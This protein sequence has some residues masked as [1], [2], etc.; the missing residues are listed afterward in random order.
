MA[1]ALDGLAWM[2]EP[3][4]LH[5][6][7]SGGTGGSGSPGYGHGHKLE[8]LGILADGSHQSSRGTAIWFRESPVGPS[9]RSLSLEKTPEEFSRGHLKIQTMHP[10]NPFAEPVR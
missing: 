2:G 8:G 6:A 10:F 9:L 1:L 4:L 3:W 5:C 7:C